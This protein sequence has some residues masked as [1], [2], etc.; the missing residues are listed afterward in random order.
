M[1]ER[2]QYINVQRYGNTSWLRRVNEHGLD[3]IETIT[4]Y[5]PT[6]YF[7][8]NKESE[9]KS[10]YNHKLQPVKCKNI[11]G[12][13]ELVERYT[14]VE[15]MEI[16]GNTRYE[17]AYLRERF[18][19][20]EFVKNERIRTV[21]ID[22]ETEVTDKF[23]KPCLAEER[24]TLITHFVDGVYH[25]FHWQAFNI[26]SYNEKN[27][28]IKEHL[29]D[30]EED[31]LRAYVNF[32]SDNYPHCV[33]GWNSDSF[34]IPY[35]ITRLKNLFGLPE[36]S[37]L[38]P[39]GKVLLTFAED[40]DG[41]VKTLKIDGISCLDYMRAF[42][43]FIPGERDFS[44]A[45]VAEDFLGETKV[46]NP[47]ATFR[48]FYLND[49]DRFCYYNVKDVDL[50]VQLDKKLGLLN[51]IYRMSYLVGMNF[52]DV[53][54]T[55]TPWEIFLA[56]K[57]ST[58]NTFLP[59]ANKRKQIPP[60][61]LMG[62]F[63]DL[64]KPGLYR[65]GLTID[66]ASLYPLLMVSFNIGPETKVGYDQLPSIL[67]K[68]YDKNHINSFLQFGIPEE[69]TNALAENE[70]TM[71]ANGMFYTTK[72]Q[73]FIA[74]IVQEVFNERKAEKNLMLKYEAE[75]EAIEEKLKAATESESVVLKKT[76]F[77]LETLVN[78]H[79]NT[80]YALK[81]LI[82]SLYGAFG[83]EWFLLYDFHNAE[84]T[85]SSG[86]YS[87]RKTSHDVNAFMDSLVGIKTS[88]HVIYNDTDSISVTIERLVNKLGIKRDD[89]GYIDS[90]AKFADTTINRVS[91][92]SCSE[93][94]TWL[95]CHQNKLAF[96]REKVFSSGLYI[97]KKRY[98][99][100]VQD[101]EGIRYAEPK[102]K[103]TG[104][105]IKRSD[106]PLFCRDALKTALS[107]ILSNT[108]KDLQK[109]V[110]EFEDEF[111]QTDPNEYAMT[112]GV[113]GI[114]K[115]SDKQMLYKKGTPMHVRAALIYNDQ[116]R[117][118]NLM[119]EYPEIAEGSKMKYLKLKM[120]NT[121]GHNVCG[122]IGAPP[123]ELELKEYVDKQQMFYDTFYKAMERMSSAAGWK[124][125]ETANV[126]EDFWF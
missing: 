112:T 40:D 38:S 88:D 15:G 108:E 97:A 7:T 34:D 111:M 70:L 82:N 53:F 69:L 102:I 36:V 31:M 74:R 115:Y 71:T 95:N 64:Y 123:A 117:A 81:I 57:L 43:K 78:I 75:V 18:G 104:L 93:I 13:R 45:A 24:I 63:V 76:L 90:L 91:A 3:V 44:L 23:P 86:Q 10:I 67:R 4:D 114:G 32:W 116:L 6:L 41:F 122:Y 28:T 65:D 61:Q 103:V 110:A 1:A 12:A 37:R 125:K 42:K 99:L 20:N 58:R 66:A 14:D 77:E 46:E 106:T 49:W 89:A 113:N 92:K 21:F 80:Q 17:Y 94:T 120:P 119:R 109:C 33:T 8:S 30:C 27:L 98:A 16:F 47:H 39:N 55:V 85:T 100:L 126:D 84:A 9:Y 83:N 35:I 124:L 19:S 60:R 101:E 11:S 29:H 51:L 96:K 121:I 79:H 26:D 107:L 25:V 48:E 52:E 62:G 118:R 105:E 54:G 56:N 50:V 87:I 59:V 2:G 73:G 22:I 5:K 72:E 68:Y